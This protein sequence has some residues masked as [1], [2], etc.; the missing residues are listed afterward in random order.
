MGFLEPSA[1]S[2]DVE[3]WRRKP[4][5][6]RLKSVVQDWAVTGFGAPGYVYLLYVVKLLIFSFGAFLVIAATT[7]GIGGL[8]DFTDWWTEPIVFQKI[9]VWTLLWEILGLGSGSLPLAGRY[10]P[11]IGGVL[12]W[13]RPGTVRLPP[14]PDKVPL[15]RGTT[16]TV[17]DVALYGGVIAVALYLLLSDGDPAGARLDT[18][19]IGILFGVWALLGLRDKVSFLAARPEVYGSF[20]VVSLLP[21][22]NFIVGW[23]LVMVCIWWGAA[24]SKLN[25]HFPYVISTMVSNTPWNRS[26]KMKR[27]LYRDWPDDMRPSRNAAFGAHLG[28]AVE[29]G[30]PLLLLVTSGGPI[31]TFALIGMIIFHVHITSTFAL[32]VP[33]EWNLF[34]IFSLAFNFGHYADVPLD[35]ADS[36]LLWLFI[37]ALVTIVV[38]G[39]ARPQWISFLP[40]MRYYAGNWASS[41]WLFRKEGDVEHQLD[42]KITKTTPITLEQLK[43]FYEPD[44]AERLMWAVEAF[45]AMHTHGRA[46]LGLL[47][48]ATGGADVDDYHVRDGEIVSG[49]VNGWNFGDGHFHHEQLLE[50]VQERCNFEPGD[51]RVVV[52]ESQ[53]IQIQRQAYRIYDAAEGLIEEGWVNV[54]DMVARGPWLE[55]NWEFPVEVTGGRQRPQEPEPAAVA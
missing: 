44:E 12:H 30:L 9:V 13:L 10:H 22:E 54:A 45:R 35:T 20:L 16:R 38:I 37:A 49:V 27:E 4:Y 55:E 34:M 29:F 18:A 39:N 47:P 48:R 17:L 32:G 46:L 28:T 15:T 25:R 11:M 23:Q 21:V 36:P 42:A 3:E 52:L 51:L 26:K 41:K 5:L 8:G 31:G 14:W 2:Y 50:A 24:S 7:P 40:S 1:P 19:A 53:P 6:S 33:L 43:R